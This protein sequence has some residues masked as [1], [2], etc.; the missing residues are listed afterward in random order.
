MTGHQGKGLVMAMHPPFPYQ[1]GGTLILTNY[2]NAFIIK[3]RNMHLIHEMMSRFLGGVIH[4]S[5]ETN[6]SADIGHFMNSTLIRSPVGSSS[7]CW[8]DHEVTCLRVYRT[9]T[10]NTSGAFK[11]TRLAA[12]NG[13]LSAVPPAQELLISQSLT[14]VPYLMPCEFSPLVFLLN[15]REARG[16]IWEMDTC[17]YGTVLRPLSA[18]SVEKFWLVLSALGCCTDPEAF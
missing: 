8:Y 16:T 6:R 3:A 7:S 11:L 1:H 12:A 10:Y 9:G 5:V 17:R 18:S 14:Q 2:F 15:A 13:S 4:C